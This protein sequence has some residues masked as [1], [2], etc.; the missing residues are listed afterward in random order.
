M[1]FIVAYPRLGYM[2]QLFTIFMIIT[3]SKNKIY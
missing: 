1:F 3:Y 2:T